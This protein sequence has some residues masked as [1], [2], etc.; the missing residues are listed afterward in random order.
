MSRLSLQQAIA[1]G[2]E[3]HQSGQLQQAEAIYRQVLQQQPD[4]PDALHLLGGIAQQVGGNDA[5]IELI[6]RA[7]AAGL[8]TAAA[9]N[10]LGEAHRRAGHDERAADYYRTSVK[11][12]P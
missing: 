8:R 3:H 12:D 9:Y 11:I 7:I 6:G 2:L 4:Q 1:L 10:N 5:A